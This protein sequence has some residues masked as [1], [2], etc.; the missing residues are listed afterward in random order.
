MEYCQ[1][2]LLGYIRDP[3]QVNEIWEL[4]DLHLYRDDK[5]KRWHRVGRIMRDILLGLNFIHECDEVHR[6]M[7]PSNGQ[8]ASLIILIHSS[9]QSW[10][11]RSMENS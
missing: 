10:Q 1:S 6:D 9:F 3:I 11:A 8:Y 2:T 4:D 7:K 5:A